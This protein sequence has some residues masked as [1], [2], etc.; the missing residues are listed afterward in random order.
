[1]TTNNNRRPEDGRRANRGDTGRRWGV[2]G[3]RAVGYVPADWLNE[4]VRFGKNQSDAVRV[5]IDIALHPMEHGSQLVSLSDPLPCGIR[6]DTASGTCGK[7]AY[8]AHANL[9][10]NPV[11]PGHW[12]LLPVCRDC[13]LAA[14]K[15]YD[16][17]DR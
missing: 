4:L 7:P 5:A 17:D 8:I 3:K 2:N 10:R 6:S 13:A 12:V 14:A 16:P 1:M 11:L 9:F 15:V